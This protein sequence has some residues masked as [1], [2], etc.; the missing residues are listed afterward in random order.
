M[1]AAVFAADF[2]PV[3]R[4]AGD[5]D[6]ACA[7]V[8]HSREV[9][10]LS[11][12][13]AVSAQL[14]RS[15][16]VGSIRLDARNDLV[17]ALGL[18]GTLDD[19]TLCLHAYRRWGDEFVGRLAGD[20]AFVLWDDDKR[21]LLGVRDQLG[22]R[23]LLYARLGPTWYASDSL[24][25]LAARPALDR[26]LD[27]VW[28]GDFLA[29]GQ[30]L[31]ASRTVYEKVHRLPPGHSVE[32]IGDRANLRR[33]WRLTIERPLFLRDSGA[34]GEC[35]RELTKAAI[36]DRA[37]SGKLGISMSGG[38][39]STSLAAL[40]VETLGDPARIVA[41]CAY[42]Q[43]LMADDEPRFAGLAAR[44]LGIDLRLDNVDDAY[45][46]QWRDRGI[47]TAEPA[48]G[49]V[50]A[51]RERAVAREMAA[52]APVWFFGEGPD[53]ALK[54]DRGPYLAWLLRKGQWARAACATARYVAIKIGE[55]RQ[56]PAAQDDPARSTPG[57]LPPWLRDELVAQTGL[58]ERVQA[59]RSPPRTHP[60]HPASVASFG[61]ASWQALF[62]SLDVDEEC[63]P[64]VWRHPYLDLRVLN[65]LLSVP[66]VPW[67][68]NKLVMRKAM[69][70]RLPPEILARKKTPLAASAMQRVLSEKSL[71]PLAN[72]QALE[73]WLDPERLPSRPGAGGAEA[74]L[75]AHALDYWL[76]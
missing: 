12:D 7:I 24:S 32:L 29:T 25:W 10:L 66:P 68:R 23:S 28:I 76:R 67:A 75:A 13:G 59:F 69:A 37:P 6:A 17:D 36:R 39:D 48:I 27:E 42:F 71:P 57:L 74:L 55:R 26:R 72:R 31:D 16:I 19:A 30:S 46:P 63:A 4:E 43:A 3:G 18:P 73:C 58:R 60:W 65:F 40:S 22:I 54:F 53:N 2:R 35:F 9:A 11:G 52:Q 47:S 45:D 70:N 8:G 56:T 44:H 14:D 21:R 34:Y 38:L 61:T 5:D 64:L 51:H 20:F 33:Y 1:F 49:I 15:W 50:N 41:R 62:S